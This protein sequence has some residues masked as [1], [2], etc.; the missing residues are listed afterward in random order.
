M[1][2]AIFRRVDLRFQ[3]WVVIAGLMLTPPYVFA[4]NHE[5]G[6]TLAHPLPGNIGVMGTDIS[7]RSLA[8]LLGTLAVSALAARP[9][10]RPPPPRAPCRPR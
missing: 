1:K 10:L 4:S 5:L 8:V 7:L 6:L 2:P 9:P 3:H